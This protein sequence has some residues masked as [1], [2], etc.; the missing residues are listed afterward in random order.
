MAGKVLEGVEAVRRAAITYL[1]P[2]T[3]LKYLRTADVNQ[4]L[5]DLRKHGGKICLTC[6]SAKPLSKFSKRIPMCSDCRNHPINS[7]V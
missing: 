3:N 4:L 1:R 7:L 5:I 6:M 2:F